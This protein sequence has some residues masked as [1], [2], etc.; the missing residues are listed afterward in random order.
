MKKQRKRKEQI[1]GTDRNEWKQS[2]IDRRLLSQF[3]HLIFLLK[4]VSLDDERDGRKKETQ[5]TGFAMRERQESD[6][7]PKWSLLNRL[8]F[9]TLSFKSL[10]KSPL[11]YFEFQIQ[12]KWVKVKYDFW[13]IIIINRYLLLHWM[14]RKYSQSFLS[15]LCPY[16]QCTLRLLSKTVQ[17]VWPKQRTSWERCYHTTGR[18]SSWFPNQLSSCPER[19]HIPCCCSSQSSLSWKPRNTCSW[20]WQTDCWCHWKTMTRDEGWSTPCEDVSES[21][22]DSSVWRFS[23]TEGKKRQRQQERVIFLAVEMKAGSKTWTTIWFDQNKSLS[24]KD[25]LRSE[26]YLFSRSRNRRPS[27]TAVSFTA[28]SFTAVSLTGLSLHWIQAAIS[29]LTFLFPKNDS[30]SFRSFILSSQSKACPKLVSIL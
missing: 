15:S 2:M 14:E 16:S 28:V 20:W 5:G 21:M 29:W 12:D 23:L 1:E 30:Q 3:L 25:C 9:F 6:G 27:F 19:N 7:G 8:L 24:S 13:V 22:R 18:I 17:S 10:L 11:K 26:V 4:Q